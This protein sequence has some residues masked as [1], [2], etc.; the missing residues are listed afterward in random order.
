[1]SAMLLEMCKK[2]FPEGSKVT[3]VGHPGQWWIVKGVR[4]NHAHRLCLSRFGT[5]PAEWVVA[6][7]YQTVPTANSSGEG[8]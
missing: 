5:E 8:T 6:G 7:G 2:L 3:R 1:M 4:V